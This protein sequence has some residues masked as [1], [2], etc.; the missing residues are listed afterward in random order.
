[1]AEG[2]GNQA[3]PEMKDL[4]RPV[5]ETIDEIHRRLEEKNVQY[6]KE[7]LKSILTG[8]DEKTQN[9]V[10]SCLEGIGKSI[11]KLSSKDPAQQMSGALDLVASV[12][13]FIPKVGPIISGVCLLISNV[14][15]AF[16]AKPS[17]TNIA[18]QLEHVLEKVIGKYHDDDV[19][20]GA[21]GISFK[22]RNMQTYLDGY[23]RTDPNNYTEQDVVNLASHD[24]EYTNVGV[25]CLGKLESYIKQYS[26][27]K[28]SEDHDAV[29]H[30]ARCALDY[31]DAYLE[32]S[33]VR[34][35]LLSVYYCILL[36]T[37][38][39]EATTNGVMRTIQLATEKVTYI[40]II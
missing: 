26:V 6:D 15:I 35:L 13:V 23:T 31:I 21:A 4:L 38:R 9:K 40:L 5:S 12:T 14:I 33:A 34:K 37:G 18:A 11:V 10:K 24:L 22:L 3:I 28:G 17:G 7:T 29:E 30:Q 32:L 36:S 27:N 19:K 39:F 16:G 1:M 20:A 2:Q 25:E 8:L